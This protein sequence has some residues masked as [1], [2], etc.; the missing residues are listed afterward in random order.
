MKKFNV[1]LVAL[2][3]F[4]IGITVHAQNSISTSGGNA[5]GSGETVS[6]S[7][8]QAVY[9]TNTSITAGSVAHGVQQPFEIS[10]ITSI[11]QA[12]DITLVY[13]AY[14]NPASEFLSLNIDNYENENL[15]YKLFDA[16][17][18][19]LKSKIVTG[20]ETIISMANLL[21]SFYFLKVIDDQKEI[22]TFKIIKK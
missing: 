14:P 15:S 2:S 20:N 22:I 21:P 17:G 4:G 10:V 1:A 11:E 5:S 18:K 3:M 9:T 7:V 12:R 16:N 13:Y 6:Y 19:L 8:G